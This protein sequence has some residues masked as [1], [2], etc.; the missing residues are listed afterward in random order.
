MSACEARCYKALLELGQPVT[1]GTIAKKA[2]IKRQSMYD[3]L[4]ALMRKGFVVE[5]NGSAVKRFALENPMKI[6]ERFSDRVKNAE[7]ERNFAQDTL[8]Q[9]SRYYFPRAGFKNVSTFEGE[10][11][12]ELIREDILNS[13]KTAMSVYSRDEILAQSPL[14]QDDSRKKFIDRPEPFLNLATSNIEH[15]Y[16]KKG[17]MEFIFLP[18]DA[19]KKLIGVNVLG[20][21]TV[22]GDK[23]VIIHIID[24]GV[25][26]E[27]EQIA[28][29]M[30]FVFFLA[31]SDAKKRIENNPM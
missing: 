30:K 3:L 7:D 21:I 17:S 27:D 31:W 12:L 26:I 4:R 15:G 2:K 14:K 1:A 19:I 13:G 18:A 8:S 5:V 6:K 11:A 20:E 25:I 22:Y 23:V 24:K 29:V 10:E 16:K 9:I 28:S